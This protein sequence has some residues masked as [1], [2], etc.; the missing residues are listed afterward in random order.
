MPNV[1]VNCSVS[2]CVF[3]KKGNLCGAEKIQVDMDYHSSDAKTEFA[4]DF[5][6]KHIKE[7]ANSSSDTCCK[8]F[9]PKNNHKEHVDFSI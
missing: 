1:E 5:D 8:T 7:E 6:F 4:S 3:H 9:K 2:N